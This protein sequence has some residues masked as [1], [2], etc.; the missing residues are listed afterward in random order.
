[1]PPKNKATLVLDTNVWI[2]F[3]IGKQLS[4]LNDLIFSDYITF[5]YSRE[6]IEE[7]SD[8]IFRSKFKKYFTAEKALFIIERI[9]HF[10]VEVQVSSQVDVCR[11]SNDN[12]LLS[13]CQDGHADFLI[14]G[15]AGLLTLE[16]FHQTKIISPS[17]F[18]KLYTNQ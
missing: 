11:D 14:T 3:L 6:L 17:F 4:N 18:L 2:S 5:I 10:G 1:M 13:L 9:L 7:L 16:T 15:D 8:T 12:F